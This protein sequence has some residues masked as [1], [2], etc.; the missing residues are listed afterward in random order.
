MDMTT[1][2]RL[3]RKVN[4]TRRLLI[5]IRMVKRLRNRKDYN[6]D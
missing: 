2:N 6:V 4:G 1:R 3:E 5:T